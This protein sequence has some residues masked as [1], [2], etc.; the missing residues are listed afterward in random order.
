[1]LKS[2]WRSPN[3]AWRVKTLGHGAA[4][5]RRTYTGA[6]KLMKRTD[7]ERLCRKLEGA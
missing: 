2:N 3:G 7:R 6:H 4:Q 5:R 1:M